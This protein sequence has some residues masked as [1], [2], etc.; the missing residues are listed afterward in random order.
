MPQSG[1]QLPQQLLYLRGISMGRQE[2][3][4]RRHCARKRGGGLSQGPGSL[5]ALFHPSLGSH[6]SVRPSGALCS[7]GF[8]GF[9]QALKKAMHSLH[10]WQVGYCKATKMLA[11]LLNECTGISETGDSEE[12]LTH[13][14]NPVLQP[15]LSSYLTQP[16]DCMELVSI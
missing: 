2:K 5:P 11:V 16:V 8:Q 13:H 1:R 10:L 9:I 4:G 12:G 3:W 15:P 6:L 14:K 7:E